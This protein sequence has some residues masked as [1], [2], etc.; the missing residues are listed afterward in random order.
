[1]PTRLPSL[2]ALRAFEAT[3]RHL[4]VTLAAE[5]LSVTQSAVSR[6]IRALEDELGLVLFRR[7][8]RAIRLSPEGEQLARALGQAF[9]G[10]GRAVEQ[11]RQRPGELRVRVPPTFGTRWLLPRLRGF[12]H[13]NPDVKV[14]VSVLW[15]NM[16][17]D[18]AEHDVAVIVNSPGWPASELVPLFEEQLAP[19]CS[20][21]FLQHHAGALANLT[22]GVPLLHCTGPQDWRQW[23]NERGP[24]ELDWSRGE[25]FDTMD[26]ALRAAEGGRGVAMADLNMILDDLDLGR[27][28]RP[29]AGCVTGQDG[30][31]LVRRDSLRPRSDVGRFVAWIV[32]EAAATRAEVA[33]RLAT[34]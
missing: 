32:A 22:P 3:A 31:F 21:G 28:V 16:S 10:I 27:L 7:L 18:D 4:S 30:L 13:A 9:E 6:H 20:P 25:V 11:V 24:G 14:R 8:H 26:M 2:N 19:V 17:P 12:E 15:E 29:L 33:R 1:M 23:A 5:E 34:D